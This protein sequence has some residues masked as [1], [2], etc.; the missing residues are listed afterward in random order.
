MKMKGYPLTLTKKN[1]NMKE[2]VSEETPEER[3]CI[4]E[5]KKDERTIHSFR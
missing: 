1:V 3:N 5:P 4:K 2:T